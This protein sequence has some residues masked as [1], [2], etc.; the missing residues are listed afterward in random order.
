[1]SERTSNYQVAGD[2]YQRLTIQPWEAMEAW[3][4]PDEFKAHLKLTA[5]KYLAR[6]G[7]KGPTRDDIAKARHYLDKW[8]EVDN[9]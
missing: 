2:H 5:I 4:T 7:S 8:L 3:S 1:M 6:A 9:G